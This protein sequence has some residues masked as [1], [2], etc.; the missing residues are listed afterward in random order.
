MASVNT[1][2]AEFVS[3]GGTLLNNEIKYTLN[4]TNNFEEI[5]IRTFP[6]ANILA[7][8]KA[9]VVGGVATFDIANYLKS[10]FTQNLYFFGNISGAIETIYITGDGFT[11]IANLIK[12]TNTKLDTL[13]SDFVSFLLKKN[14]NNEPVLLN[15]FAEIPII[16]NSFASVTFLNNKNTNFASSVNRNGVSL[17]L[18]N[19]TFYRLSLSSNFDDVFFTWNDSTNSKK[20]TFKNYE[21]CNGSYILGWYNNLG[22][23]DY[24]PFESF[25]LSESIIDSSK[26][27]GYGK[28]N[29]TSIT[30]TKQKTLR[31]STFVT[32]NEYL[33]ILGILT[34]NFIFTIDSNG[35]FLKEVDLQTTNLTT[36]T[37]RGTLYEV[38]IEVLLPFE[39]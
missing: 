22:G 2:P 5:Q 6:S 14:S 11:D 28:F 30:K 24:F 15:K 18:L 29:R 20:L 4:S 34:S 32:E 39:N 33:G 9:S 36:F 35:N 3:V 7:T 17:S 25:E 23:F 31:L 10:L 37:K 19:T 1:R 8:L 26:F 27:L 21:V 13:S 38:S 16:N 12:V